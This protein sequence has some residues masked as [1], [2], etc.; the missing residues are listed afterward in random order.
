MYVA[1]FLHESEKVTLI[2]QMKTCK[3]CGA[4]NPKEAKY[5]NVCGHQLKTL[6]GY[7]KIGLWAMGT[8]AIVLAVMCAIT[9]IQLQQAND[10]LNAYNDT[11]MQRA[12]HFNTTID[13][14][15]REFMRVDA[16]R[17]SAEHRLDDFQEMVGRIYPLI[18]DSIEIGNV[19]RT[20]EAIR[21]FGSSIHSDEAMFLQPRIHYRGILNGNSRIYVKWFGPDGQL[22]R[23]D[24]SPD[25]YSQMTDCYVYE[26]SKILNLKGWGS[27]NQRFWRSGHYRL[28]VWC[29]DVMLGNKHFYIH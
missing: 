15:Q 1:R 17:C 2:G 8:I 27:E 14:L 16:M 3:S 23:G 12:S 28:E 9:W 13:S 11:A 18:I 4:T 24:N 10:R 20:Q 6:N 21:P 26:E 29:N 19:N 5:C 7:G 22:I 25:G